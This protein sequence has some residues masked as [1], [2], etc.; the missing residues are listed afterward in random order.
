MCMRK[1]LINFFHIHTSRFIE[2]LIIEAFMEN[3]NLNFI[4]KLVNNE[5]NLDKI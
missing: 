4:N 5:I 2:V 1:D 3:L